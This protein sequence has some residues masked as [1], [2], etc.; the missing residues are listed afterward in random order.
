MFDG[1]P[2]ATMDMASDQVE[3]SISPGWRGAV[4]RGRPA[5]ARRWATRAA[6]DASGAE[7]SPDPCNAGSRSRGLRSGSSFMVIV[8][9]LAGGK[10]GN[11]QI[12]TRRRRK[13][14]L[15]GGEGVR[16]RTYPQKTG[17]KLL[18]TCGQ[19]FHWICS[20]FNLISCSSWIVQHD[21]DHY[22]AV[23]VVA[24]ALGGMR[25]SR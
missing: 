3:A 4:V 5:D 12:E 22:R 9:I 8:R 11:V 6:T 15:G 25:W 20:V 7:R 2:A 14:G 13:R 1:V 23:W 17:T 16:L 19:L 21:N 18:V 10:V 24:D